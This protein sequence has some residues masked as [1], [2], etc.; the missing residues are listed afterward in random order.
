VALV[1]T[2]DLARFTPNTHRVPLDLLATW[3]T[4]ETGAEVLLV[5]LQPRQTTLGE[6]V[7]AEVGEA[8]RLV[9]ATLNRALETRAGG[10]P[11]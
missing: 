10:F 3:L 9:A 7:S 1:E 6:P 11:C 8:A 4:R 5:A 2:R